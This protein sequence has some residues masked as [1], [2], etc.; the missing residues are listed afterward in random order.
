MFDPSERNDKA[1]R[2]STEKSD[3]PTHNLISG[4]VLSSNETAVP[5]NQLVEFD[6][7][8][9]EPSSV[10]DESAQPFESV[11]PTDQK[12]SESYSKL[13]LYQKWTASCARV[14]VMKTALASTKRELKDLQKEKH[15]T[16]RELEVYKQG[17][18]KSDKLTY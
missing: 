18:T 16:V 2:V 10:D 8:S 14:S 13:S 4:A 6:L 1:A 9:S 17:K 5:S 11:Q 3:I 7:T 12:A 15:L